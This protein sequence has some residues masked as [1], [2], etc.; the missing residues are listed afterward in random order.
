MSPAVADLPAQ[1]TDSTVTR[2]RGGFLV[3]TELARCAIHVPFPDI[4]RTRPVT[5]G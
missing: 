3:A 5:S 2:A 1:L 4:R